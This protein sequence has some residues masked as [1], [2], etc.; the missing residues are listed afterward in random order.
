[1][2]YKSKIEDYYDR[3]LSMPKHTL[4]YLHIPKAA[5]NSAISIL[6]TNDKNHYRVK[7]DDVNNSWETLLNNLQEEK[8]Y[9]LI[10]GHYKWNHLKRIKSDVNIET[11]NITFIRNPIHRL[12]SEYKYMTTPSHPPYLKFRESFPTFEKWL[13]SETAPTNKISKSLCPS[14]FYI[15]DIIKNTIENFHFIGVHEIFNTSMA[16]L[17]DLLGLKYKVSIP[18]NV[19]QKN[20]FNQF[21]LSEKTIQ[22]I[23]EQNKS[24]LMLYNYIYMEFYSDLIDCYFKNKHND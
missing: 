23:K 9:S 20:E 4:A 8:K 6:N 5:G 3:I 21:E 14:S 10:S 1:M 19:T 15:E 18:K 11:C 12:V 2:N 22:F 16:I 13:Y 7:W 24:D 17:C